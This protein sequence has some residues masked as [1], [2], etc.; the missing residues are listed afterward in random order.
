MVHI[1]FGWLFGDQTAVIWI[2]QDN[3]YPHIFTAT[4]PRLKHNI[5]F[6]KNPS[7]RTLWMD[8]FDSM[9]VLMSPISLSIKNRSFNTT[10]APCI[11]SNCWF[12]KLHIYPHGT[13]YCVI[14]LQYINTSP[15]LPLIKSTSTVYTRTQWSASIT[16]GLY[17]TYKAA[18][19]IKSY[20]FKLLLWNTYI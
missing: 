6:L 5:S 15:T 8:H 13:C 3:T 9:H 17:L 18:L 14:A 4:D 19:F 12:A 20:T 7:H 10:Q 16:T 2:Q 1:Q 11:Y